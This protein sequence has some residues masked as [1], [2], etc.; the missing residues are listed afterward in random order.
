[1]TS[2]IYDH[3]R[4]P[5]SETT[6][7]KRARPRRSSGSAACSGQCKKPRSSGVEWS[8]CE[9]AGRRR[10]F[11][12]RNRKHG[13]GDQ[14]LQGNVT[15]RTRRAIYNAC[16]VTCAPTLTKTD[17]TRRRKRKQRGA[18]ERS[19][20]SAI[21]HHEYVQQALQVPGRVRGAIGP[22]ATFFLKRLGWWHAGSG[23]SQQA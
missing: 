3:G 20:P 6:S 19:S 4:I 5:D 23:G 12:S 14:G 18:A 21:F 7:L 9:R 17:V 13:V 10:P 2:R 15:G 11:F 1:M 16:K 22:L 8:R